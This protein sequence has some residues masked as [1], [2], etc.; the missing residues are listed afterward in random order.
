MIIRWLLRWLR[1]LFISQLTAE[2]Q[3]YLL[4]YHGFLNYLLFL[5]PG[6]GP[7]LCELLHKVA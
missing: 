3:E 6:D 2:R 4:R 5:I 7:I 1:L